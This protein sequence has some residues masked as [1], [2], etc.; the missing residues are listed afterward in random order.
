MPWTGAINERLSW[1]DV[2]PDGWLQWALDFDELPTYGSVAGPLS[3][4][5]ADATDGL[6]FTDASYGWTPCTRPDD[7]PSS[8]VQL[9]SHEH[10]SSWLY[11]RDFFR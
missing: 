3:F 5:N 9:A 4:S 7:L 6:P 10:H 11:Q 1:T 2:S 8:W